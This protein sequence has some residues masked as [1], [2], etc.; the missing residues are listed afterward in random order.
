[1][2]R[3]KLHKNLFGEV[4]RNSGK[5]PS[6]PKICLLLYLWS[7]ITPFAPLLKRQ[8]DECTRYVS[9]FRLPCAHYS[10]HTL[11]TRCCWLQFV[12]V[13]NIN[14]RRYPKTEQFITTKI[15]GIAL[16]QGIEHTHCYVRV[17]H[18]CKNTRLRECLAEEQSIRAYAPGIANTQSWQFET[19]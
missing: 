19:G 17:V 5:N 16:K 15:S 11:F 4:W 6:Q 18:N 8:R 14:H 9:I 3:K 13:M 10:A 12:T 1:M 2:C 7:K